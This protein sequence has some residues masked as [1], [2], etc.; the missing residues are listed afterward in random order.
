MTNY[1]KKMTL[2]TAIP[3][4]RERLRE[5]ASELSGELHHS[6]TRVTT[7]ELAAFTE[8]GAEVEKERTLI[9]EL[10]YIQCCRESLERA[11]AS[12]GGK[13]K[14]RWLNGAI[15]VVTFKRDHN[16]MRMRVE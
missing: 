15:T 4:L 2:Q 6:V 9:E 10:L 3:V 16:Q 11:I 8:Y 1:T 12:G 5:K 7:V 14:W 13:L